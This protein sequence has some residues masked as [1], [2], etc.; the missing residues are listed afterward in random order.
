MHHNEYNWYSTNTTNRFQRM[1]VRER[2]YPQQYSDE[3][4]YPL[5]RTTDPESL[6]MRSQLTT[7]LQEKTLQKWAAH[8]KE[9]AD[10]CLLRKRQLGLRHEDSD[11]SWRTYPEKRTTYEEDDH[12][13]QGGSDASQPSWNE[14]DRSKYVL[15]R[16]VNPPSVTHSH[17]SPHSTADS[18]QIFVD[19]S[20]PSTTQM[21]WVVSGKENN[22]KH[23]S[24]SD[25]NTSNSSETTA[26]SPDIQRPLR[27]SVSVTTDRGPTLIVTVPSVSENGVEECILNKYGHCFAPT[28]CPF[29]H[30]GSVKST[31]GKKITAPSWPLKLPDTNI[32]SGYL[33]FQCWD[34]NCEKRHVVYP[35]DNVDSQ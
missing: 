31:K 26:S 24:S 32:C 4:R 18:D 2:P 30:N 13:T 17:S 7:P 34:Y 14:Y 33:N 20:Q 19:D 3:G 5:G 8:Q 15:N 28:I 23:V 21:R 6:K 16:K 9:M 35:S 1:I 27:K 22:D 10:Q 12:E 25:N 11:P 29:S